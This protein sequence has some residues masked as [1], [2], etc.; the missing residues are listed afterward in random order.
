MADV[1]EVCSDLQG[2]LKGCEWG[3][4]STCLRGI[5]VMDKRKIPG[6]IPVKWMLISRK[7][8][9]IVFELYREKA[10]KQNHSEILI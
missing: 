5:E 9:P 4:V 10:R 8:T 6:F 2:R 7:K 3:S 1:K